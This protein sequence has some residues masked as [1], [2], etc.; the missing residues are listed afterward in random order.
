MH[1][2]LRNKFHLPTTYYNELLV[3]QFYEA[4]WQDLTEVRLFVV[5]F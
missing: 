1:T 3:V 2:I 5:V 4:D